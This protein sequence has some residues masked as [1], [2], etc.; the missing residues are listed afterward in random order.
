MYNVYGFNGGGVSRLK[1]SKS[2]SDIHFIF[3]ISLN[4]G[5]PIGFL[6]RHFVKKFII[7]TGRNSGNLITDCLR[8]CLRLSLSGTVMGT[9]PVT[10]SYAK[11]AYDHQ[12]AENP[13]P[14]PVNISGAIYSSVPHILNP[15]VVSVSKYLLK[16]KS[17]TFT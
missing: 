11:T 6:T 9:T 7:T 10:S 2:I 13:Y 12:S 17:V 4:S 15:N 5:R 16:P 3:F 14:T 8:V 1:L